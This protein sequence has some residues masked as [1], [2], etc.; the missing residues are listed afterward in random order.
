M[1]YSEEKREKALREFLANEHFRKIYKDAPSDRVRERLKNRFF[2]SMYGYC[3]E[4]V[5]KNKNLEEQFDI[6]DWKYM[7]KC[8]GKN[9]Y[10][11]VCL[12]N[13][14][15]VEAKKSSG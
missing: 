1:K 13:I 5:D 10:I 2:V 9:P 15:R 14:E 4:I 7:L 3:E 8:S 6:E 11:R 12:D